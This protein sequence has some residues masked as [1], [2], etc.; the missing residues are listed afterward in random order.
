MRIEYRHNLTHEEAYRRINNLII[1]MQREHAD[2]IS[3][4]K[5]SWNHERTRMDYSMMIM[6]FST[7]GQVTL[8]EGKISLKG[9]LP[10]M[11]K[12]FSGKIEEM[13]REQLKDLLA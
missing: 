5:M 11:A 4:P 10:L 12:M 2:K 8:S 6:G 1:D 3:N 7:R 13:V 9:E